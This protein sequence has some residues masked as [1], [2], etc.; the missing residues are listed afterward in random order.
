MTLSQGYAAGQ[1]HM[2]RAQGSL[3]I[4]QV[5]VLCPALLQRVQVIIHSAD[6]QDLPQ[7]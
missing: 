5:S 7:A 4:G 6:V 2:D 3:F 1:E